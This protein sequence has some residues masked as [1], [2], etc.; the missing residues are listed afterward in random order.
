M[1]AFHKMYAVIGTIVLLLG[2][3]TVARGQTPPSFFGM[4]IH[5]GVL[6][7]QP[8]PTVSL[9]SIRLRDTGTTWNDSRAYA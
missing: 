2:A 8:W 5:S 9:C 1:I 7:G 6:A 4:D 3:S